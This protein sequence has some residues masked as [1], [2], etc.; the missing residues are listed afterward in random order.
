MTVQ[1]VKIGK[2]GDL[3]HSKAKWLNLKEDDSSATKLPIKKR[4]MVEYIAGRTYKAIVTKTWEHGRL[5]FFPGRKHGKVALWS[6]Y[7]TL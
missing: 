1:T 7:A 2:A 5:E 3:I 6:K 4:F